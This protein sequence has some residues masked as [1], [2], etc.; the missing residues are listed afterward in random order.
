M[1]IN[2]KLWYFY[3]LQVPYITDLTTINLIVKVITEINLRFV[4]TKWIE[5]II[6]EIKFKDSAIKKN[7]LINNCRLHTPIDLQL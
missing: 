2:W 5:K 3:K 6:T 1:V 4:I 7:K